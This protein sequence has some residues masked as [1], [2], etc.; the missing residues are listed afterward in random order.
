M[1]LNEL[2]SAASVLSGFE[3]NIFRDGEM[4]LTN[5]GGSG[6]NSTINRYGQELAGFAKIDFGRSKH[7]LVDFNSLNRGLWLVCRSSRAR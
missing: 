7:W 1:Q 2:L 6:L 5:Q 3:V 4:S